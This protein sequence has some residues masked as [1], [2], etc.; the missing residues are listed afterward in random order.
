MQILSLRDST[1]TAEKRLGGRFLTHFMGR[2][3]HLNEDMTFFCVDSGPGRA[4]SF[5]TNVHV[6]GDSDTLP[7]SAAHRIVSLA[8]VQALDGEELE[9]A[10]EFLLDSY[11]WWAAP[12]HPPLLSDT[13]TTVR[14]KPKMKHTKARSLDLHEA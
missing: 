12:K 11:Q 10:Y 8:I 14:S 1:D 5:S 9:S 7:V 13:R 4:V 6:T 2:S 3:A